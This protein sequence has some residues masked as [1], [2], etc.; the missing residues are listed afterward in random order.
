M[1]INQVKHP[2]QQ[3]KKKESQL[4]FLQHKNFFTKNGKVHIDQSEKSKEAETECPNIAMF[5][6]TFQHSYIF[7]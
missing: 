1:S 2:K 5:V 6:S 4:L 3:K 7:L